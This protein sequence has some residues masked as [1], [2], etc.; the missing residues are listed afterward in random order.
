MTFAMTRITKPRGIR[1]LAVFSL[2]VTTIANTQAG[3]VSVIVTDAAGQPLADAVVYLEAAGKQPLSL[4]V[5]KAIIEQKAYKF[6]PLVTAVQ[7]GAEVLFPNNDAVRHN[8]YSF[9]AAKTF[10]LK[11]YSGMPGAPVVF[12]KPGTV[13]VGCNIHD[14]MVAYI[15]VVDTPYFARTDATGMARIENVTAGK[16]TL[17]SWHYLLAEKSEPSEQMITLTAADATA[18][19]RVGVSAPAPR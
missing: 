3:N 9:S 15:H 12:D 19:A 11:L 13:V 1:V 7:V 14:R 18:S 6:A 10:E 16:F 2:L 17:K 8:V 4:P 5:R